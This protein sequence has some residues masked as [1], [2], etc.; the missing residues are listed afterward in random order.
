MLHEVT[1]KTAV[2][3]WLA[4]DGSVRAII[5]EKDGEERLIPFERLF[6]GARFVV[7]KKAAKVNIDVEAVVRGM[8]S[9]AEDFE[10][11]VQGMISKGC[12][13]SAADSDKALPESQPEPEGPSGGVS[14]EKPAG[15]AA[16]GTRRKKVDAG[17]LRALRTAGWSLKQIGVE[18]GISE[19]TAFR[20]LKKLEEDE[21][22]KRI[23]E[24]G[25]GD[26]G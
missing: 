12:C 18:F 16:T 4:G 21:V 11:A 7:D 8:V 10:A 20:L 19:S 9:T 22:V 6:N 13:E 5:T 2:E 23:A 1:L 3:A 17:K 26:K 24:S 14:Q 25:K 15:D